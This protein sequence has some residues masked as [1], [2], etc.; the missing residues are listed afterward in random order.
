MSWQG[1]DWKYDPDISEIA[2]PIN[3]TDNYVFNIEDVYTV[4]HSGDVTTDYL[5]TPITNV[6]VL[7]AFA[8]TTDITSIEI[9][10]SV[11]SIGDF[12]FYGSSLQ[13]A[14]I[15]PFL[16]YTDGTFPQS[17][18]IIY[19]N[20]TNL[21][22]VL[23]KTEYNVNDSFD[24]STCTV[25]VTVY[26]GTEYETGVVEN[27][28]VVDFDT[29]QEGEIPLKIRYNGTVYNTG[30]TIT[31]TNESVKIVDLTNSNNWSV[32]NFIYPSSFVITCDDIVQIPSN[33][34]SVE[35]LTTLTN[36]QASDSCYEFFKT[37]QEEE[38]YLNN[39]TAPDPQDYADG[40]QG[41]YNSVLDETSHKIQLSGTTRKSFV[42]MV[43]FKPIASNIP[44]TRSNLISCKIKFELDTSI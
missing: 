5:C 36:N 8:Y 19:W 35:I 41:T 18:S 21:S 34:T 27:Y 10:I 17:T 16:N 1:T 32:K 7:G 31:V 4:F 23:T 37:A 33:A 30:E 22:C 25:T 40:W 3:I 26:D 42:T 13:T 9:P 12:S 44:I 6:P 14:K 43:A 38:N 28:E 29:S 11:K 20:T 24:Y 39:N 15:S 2:I